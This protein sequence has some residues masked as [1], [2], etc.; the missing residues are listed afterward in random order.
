M[1][2]NEQQVSKY[3][4]GVSIN[5]R[6]DAL[7]KDSHLHSRTGQFNK[8]NLDLDC[9]WSEFAR[10]LK[11]LEDKKKNIKSYEQ[12]KEEFDK[13]DVR[14]LEHGKINDKKPEGFREVT[15]KEEEARSGHYKI[16]REKQLFLARLENN[17]GKGT[18]W[19]TDDE[20]EI[21]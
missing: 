12:V 5:L 19:N 11:D 2:E 8:W 7:W 4:S 6:V 20:D 3:S 15:Q 18:T 16:L 21:D 1:E 13:F 17:L 14:I 10:D 9:I